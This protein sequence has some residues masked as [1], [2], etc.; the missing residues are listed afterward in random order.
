MSTIGLIAPRNTYI[1]REWVYRLTND[2]R[3]L[4]HDM[5]TQFYVGEEGRFNRTM[6]RILEELATENNRVQFA[7]VLSNISISTTSLKRLPPH[8]DMLIPAGIANV[9]PDLRVSKRD[10][11]IF[12]R[13]GLV[14]TC[15]KRNLGSSDLDMEYTNSSGRIVMNL[16]GMYS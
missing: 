10:E 15:V 13:S 8:A 1:P 9:P 16:Y 2:L 11:W 5:P 6:Q 7:V 14:V 12:R 3:R 4:S